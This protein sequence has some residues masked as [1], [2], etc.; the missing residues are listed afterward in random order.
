[1]VEGKDLFIIEWLYKG[2]LLSGVGLLLLQAL[3]SF[4]RVPY[5]KYRND[6]KWGN[7]TW[8]SFMVACKVHPPTGWFIQEATSLFIPLYLIWSFGGRYV[9]EFNPNMVLLGM[10]LLHY[11]HR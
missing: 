4:G 5:G 6:S 11:A 8:G 10:Y 9:G 1:M 3:S 2:M 7:S